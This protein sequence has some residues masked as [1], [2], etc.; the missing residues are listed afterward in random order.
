MTPQ[1][2]EDQ[3]LE[4][5]RKI[6]GRMTGVDV[7][8][9][10]RPD[11]EQ[12][13]QPGCDA[14]AQ[15]GNNLVAIE[16]TTIDPYRNRRLDDDRFRRVVLPIAPLVEA[17]FPDSWI[18]LEVPVHAIPVG[19]DWRQ[20]GERLKD[21]VL[22]SLR[23][24]PIAN[25]SDLSRTRFNSQD[26][27]FPVW[28][29]RQ[30]A[31]VGPRCIIFRQ[32]PGDLYQQLDEDIHRALVDKSDQLAQ[33]RVQGYRAILLLEFD[34][35][36]LL[37]QDLVAGSFARAADITPE[38]DQIDD[39]YLVDSRRAS[40]WVFPVQMG[41]DRFPRLQ[42]FQAFFSEQYRARYGDG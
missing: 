22:N 23:G 27:P 13:G 12:P 16:H 31:D 19:Q 38:A 33:Y 26:L 24:M 7:K 9:V 10:S 18:E 25:Y 39:V 29:S 3:A 4:C 20:L 35:V 36:V 15:L 1:Q 21:L 30:P 40:P 17:A 14:T 42:A 2:R 28:I 37:N 8:I 41:D 5:W 34:D 32:A 11:R 6:V